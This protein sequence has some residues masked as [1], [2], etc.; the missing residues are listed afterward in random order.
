MKTLLVAILLLAAA[1]AQAQ[2]VWRCGPAANV[3]SHSPCAD[4]RTVAVADGR[5]AQE[6]DAA[7][8]VAARERALADTLTR[9]R[10]ERERE[11]RAELGSGL[12]GI[13]P[14]PRPQIKPKSAQPK[15][16]WKKPRTLRLAARGT[17]PAA[18]PASRR[19][20]D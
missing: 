10:V 16:K 14:A 15:L 19:F 11:A 6:V 2:T 1:A 3:Y 12:A 20:V 7:R 17:S 13:K 5:D 8:A 18:A 9:Q 4:G